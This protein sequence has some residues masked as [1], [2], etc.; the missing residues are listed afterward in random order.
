MNCAAKAP[1]YKVSLVSPS[2]LFAE[3]VQNGQISFITW[4]K[5][6]AD[7]LNGTFSQDDEDVITRLIYA[8][9]RGLVKVVD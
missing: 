8:V 4:Q 7:P 3:A 9:R 2:E 1:M 6:M 5:L